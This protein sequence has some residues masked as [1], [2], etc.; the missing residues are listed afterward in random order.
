MA[1]STS[2]STS[3]VPSGS[4]SINRSRGRFSA[5]RPRHELDHREHRCSYRRGSTNEGRFP[6]TNRCS[7][8]RNRTS[9]NN[10]ICGFLAGSLV[11]SLSRGGEACSLASRSPRFK[12]PMAPSTQ[13]AFAAAHSRRQGVDSDSCSSDVLLGQEG[14]DLLRGRAGRD[15]LLASYTPAVG[16]FCVRASEQRRPLGSSDRLNPD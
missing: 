3:D 8:A 6:E 2:R 5:R 4:H 16:R 12:E 15:E 1:T 7:R 10:A 13:H 14:G 11:D 9:K